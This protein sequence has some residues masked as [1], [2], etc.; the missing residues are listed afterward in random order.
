MVH[1]E[2]SHFNIYMRQLIEVDIYLQE[3]ASVCAYV[4]ILK[5]YWLV[6]V[7]KRE[8]DIEIYITL[9]WR[10]YSRS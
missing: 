1:L 2:R 9:L 5:I 8:E 3:N 7:T 4:F 10:L 6:S